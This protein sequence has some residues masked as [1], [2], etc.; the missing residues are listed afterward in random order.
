MSVH[1]LYSPLP[2]RLCCTLPPVHLIGSWE[3]SYK[4]QCWYVDA[5]ATPSISNS[6][7]HCCFLKGANVDDVGKTHFFI[8][9]LCRTY[10]YCTHAESRVI[11]NDMAA[12]FCISLNF[13]YAY[14]KYLPGGNVSGPELCRA[15]GSLLFLPVRPSVCLFLFD[16]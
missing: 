9:F 10:L 7:G 16:Y 4:S 12:P 14:S 3:G 15:E 5:D 2:T 1:T 8:L 13:N 6:W 11:Q